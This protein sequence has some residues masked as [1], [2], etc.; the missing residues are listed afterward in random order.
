MR[1]PDMSLMHSDDWL[2][3]SRREREERL[4]A[5]RSRRTAAARPASGQV[6]RRVGG[7]LIRLGVLVGGPTVARPVRWVPAHGRGAAR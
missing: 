1:L 5:V 2:D 4:H 3:V 6:R 7:A